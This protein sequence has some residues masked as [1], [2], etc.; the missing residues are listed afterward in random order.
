MYVEKKLGQI[1]IKNTPG[2]VSTYDVTWSHKA[3]EWRS[4]FKSQLHILRHGVKSDLV[5]SSQR[6]FLHGR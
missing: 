1:A 4:R 2:K 6:E 5:R 3:K